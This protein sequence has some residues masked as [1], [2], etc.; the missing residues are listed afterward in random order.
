MK[1]I[2]K[3]LVI[4][5]LL[6][7]AHI[8]HAQQPDFWDE[9]QS[10]KHS[11]SIAQ[12]PQHSILF[13]GSSSFRM[14]G[15]VQDYF[16]GYTIINRGFG[17]SSFPDLI[18][19]ED[20]IIVPYKP[21]Q[22]LIYCGDNDL[23]SSDTV[24]AE[25]VFERFKILFSDIR[26]KLGKVP[27]AYVAIKPSPSRERLMP[28]MLQANM[29]IKEYLKHKNKTAFIDVYHAMLTPDGKPM[30]GIFKEDNLH[31]NQKGYAIWQKVIEPYLKK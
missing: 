30:P 2:F 12:P 18:R 1:H 16:P 11:D 28:K 26:S 8:A 13:V 15:D 25:M 5:L 6:L 23:A 10:F 19:Y 4:V 21:K 22:I 14:W 20:D 17:G 27:V 9:I 7:S 29:L 31:M 3:Q 24:T